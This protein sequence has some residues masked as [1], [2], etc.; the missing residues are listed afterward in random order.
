MVNRN[1]LY[2]VVFKR[3]KGYDL[4]MA[5]EVRNNRLAYISPGN[6]SHFLRGKLKTVDHKSLTFDTENFGE[7]IFNL[8]TLKYF[9]EVVL[10]EDRTICFDQI[11]LNSFKTDEDL[12]NCYV[13]KFFDGHLPECNDKSEFF[14]SDMKL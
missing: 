13:Q 10:K 7:V 11:T 3:H 6:R 9:K 14:N 1:A 8:A 2:Q 5:I 12:W 4:A